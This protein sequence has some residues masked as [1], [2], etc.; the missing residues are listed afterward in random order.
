MREIGSFLLLLLLGAS[1]AGLPRAYPQQ[2]PFEGGVGIVYA[3]GHAFLLKAPDGWVLDREWRGSEPPEPVFYPVGFTAKDSPVLIR[4]GSMRAESAGTAPIERF[5]EERAQVLAP[6][7]GAG[8]RAER[9]GECRLGKGAL[10]E[11]Y[12][13]VSEPGG[14]ALLERIGCVATADSVDYIIL[15]AKD[16]AFYERSLAAF[17]SILKSYIPFRGGPVYIPR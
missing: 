5:L 4:S 9:V 10:A 13:F 17:A 7:S 6:P 14:Q 15:D 3:P 11:V 16:R 12:S 2:H 1:L 8:A